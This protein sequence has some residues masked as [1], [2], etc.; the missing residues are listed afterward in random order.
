MA[1][2]KNGEFQNTYVILEEIGKGG[3][4]TVLK[5]YHRRLQ[6]EVVLKRIHSNLKNMNARAETDI[7]KN[8]KH[9]YLPQV[10]DFLE[11]ESGTYTV[12]DFI[13]G[14]SLKEC[15]DDGREFTQE[16]IIR[17]FKQLCEAL[18]LLHA[19]KPPIIHGDI[20]PANIMLT[21]DDNICLIDF[22]ISGMFEGGDAAVT[23]YTPG[24]ASPEQIRCYR[25]AVSRQ[26]EG[27]KPAD[28]QTERGKGGETAFLEEA[29]EGGETEILGKDMTEPTVQTESSDTGKRPEA[30]GHTEQMDERSDIYSLGATIYHLL[31]GKRI[32]AETEKNAAQELRRI[33]P[34][35]SEPLAAIVGKCVAVKP[36]NRYQSVPELYQALQNIYQSTR[37]YQR[38][39]LQQRVMRIV[40]CVAAAGFLFMAYYGK[41]RMQYEKDAA[42]LELVA[43]ERQAVQ[44]GEEE[45]LAAAYEQAILLYPERAEAYQVR[46]EYHYQAGEYEEA[47]QFLT[48]LALPYVEEGRGMANLYLLMGDC[49]FELEQYEKAEETLLLAKTYDSA[50][51]DIYRELAAAQAR[52]GKPAK[53]K[54]TVAEAEAA[55]LADDGIAYI[56]GE[57][58][59]A[60]G[61]TAEADQ[62]FEQAVQL[63]DDDY[64]RMRACLMRV[65]IRTEG[66]QTEDSCR[67]RVELLLAAEADLPEQYEN[68]ILEQLAQAYIDLAD[69]TGQKEPDMLAVSTLKKIIEKGWGSYVTHQ[70][71]VILYQKHQMLAEEQA[72]LDVMQDLY[73]E[74]YRIYKYRSL[75]EVAIQNEKD[76]SERSYEMFREYYLRAEEL[77]QEQKKGNRSDAQMQALSQLYQDMIDGGWL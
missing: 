57:I 53:A 29:G 4:G 8:L 58:A 73:G 6:K 41:T 5:A 74:D 39:L 50:N 56:N 47:L 44:S 32:P 15:L 30:T 64:L 23:G 43:A 2:Q 10:L 48:E 69:I 59:F 51:G 11:D 68:V 71:L 13:R 49:Y 14:E 24:Y 38:L 22:N 17:W 40:L 21:P 55:G 60:G 72:Q 61:D 76:S 31:T 7:L 36:E 42:Y 9:A 3:G 26:K 67:E 27:R 35:V 77:Y 45:R 25:Q 12:M 33:A 19:Q 63:A 65:R 28:L 18:M 70:N 37:Q 75:L 34:K 66:E 52:A 62:C 1:G 54:E 46:A 16:E 20:K